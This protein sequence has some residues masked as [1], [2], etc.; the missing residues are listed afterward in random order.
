MEKIAEED[1]D[2]TADTIEGDCDAEGGEK[3]DWAA[4]RPLS[5]QHVRIPALRP[6][7]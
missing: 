5:N 2:D 6:P 4:A 7:S 1:N 3:S